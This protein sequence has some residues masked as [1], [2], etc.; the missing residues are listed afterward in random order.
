MSFRPELI[1]PVVGTASSS[2]DTYVLLLCLDF[3]LCSR[4]VRGHLSSGLEK[5]QASKEKMTCLP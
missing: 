3:M 4:G 5:G 1:Y 2:G